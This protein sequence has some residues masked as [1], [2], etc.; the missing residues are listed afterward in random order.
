MLLDGQET[1][2]PLNNNPEKGTMILLAI[3]HNFCHLL[4]L[5]RKEILKYCHQLR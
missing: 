3:L 4:I 5:N 2:F 1:S